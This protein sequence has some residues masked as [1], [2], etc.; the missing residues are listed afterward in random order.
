MISIVNI[1]Y[2]AQAAFNLSSEDFIEVS[3]NVNLYKLRSTSAV[4][5]ISLPKWKMANNGLQENTGE[6]YQMFSHV[7]AQNDYSA[8]YY[9]DSKSGKK[10]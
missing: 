10:P 7:S 3:S 2:K 1:N 5:V 6:S 8:I 9:G 4:Q